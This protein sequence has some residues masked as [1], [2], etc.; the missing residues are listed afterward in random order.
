MNESRTA[1]LEVANSLGLEFHSNIPT[2][3]LAAIVAEAKGE[4]A[5]V[6]EAAPQ[7]P[8]VKLEDDVPADPKVQLSKYALKRQKIAAAKKRAMRTRVVTI[9]NKDNREN[10]FMT[11]AYVSFENQHFALSKVVPLDLPVEL[12]NALIQILASTTMTL[13]KDEVVEGKR[14]G[15][16][17]PV[18][19][20]KFA[21]SYGRE[22]S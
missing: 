20:K 4:P 12:E 17:V 1:L 6:E 15:N 13:H 14:T 2:N 7:G 5:P 16:K 9:T 10:D 11:T 22:Q 3:K 18:R 21:I 19:V 8:K